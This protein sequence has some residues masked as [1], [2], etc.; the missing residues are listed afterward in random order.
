MTFIVRSSACYLPEKKVS[1]L[2]LDRQLNLPDGICESRYH[3]EYRHYAARHETALFM[4]AQAAKSALQEV[5][6]TLADIDLVICA[7]G[8][9]HQALPYNAA[10]I[11]KEMRQ[12]AD[13][14]S[15]DI[16]SSCLSFLSAMEVS[17]AL[18]ISGRYQRILIVSS[19]VASVGIDNARP[20]IATMFG[21][22]SAAF[23]LQASDCR[24]GFHSSLFRTYPQGYSL[25]QIRAGGSNLH[26]SH[27]SEKVFTDGAYFEMQGK[28]LY[29][30]VASLS[31]AFI[32]QGL[33]AAGLKK[34]D[35]DYIVPHQASGAGLAHLTRRLG[36]SADRV[37]NIFSR[38]GNQIAASLPMAL[39][40]LIKSKRSMVGRDLLL[41]GSGAGLTMGLGILSL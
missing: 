11:V 40:E 19:E 28:E 13:V 23:I 18:I 15:M 12:P 37:V 5:D 33:H 39:H 25:C 6:M 16:N 7:S 4:A 26:P 1:A 9:S 34:S 14:A 32:D 3:V 22:G 17:Q 27:A 20:E 36:F 41:I 24:G 10:G 38:M 31:P 8:T 30:L 29:R 35:I 21:D 2:D